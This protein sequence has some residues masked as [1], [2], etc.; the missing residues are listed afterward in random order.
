M[1]THV[2]VTMIL[3]ILILKHSCKIMESIKKIPR[4]KFRR[5]KTAEKKST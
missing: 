2:R 4:K 3:L 5:K 1:L